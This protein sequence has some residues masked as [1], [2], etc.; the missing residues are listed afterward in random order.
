MSLDSERI[1]TTV[2]VK[3]DL[4]VQAIL[5]RHLRTYIGRLGPDRFIGSVFEIVFVF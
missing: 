1:L 5:L 4:V 2:L 3:F